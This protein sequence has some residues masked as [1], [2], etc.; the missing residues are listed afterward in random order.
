M[1]E[2]LSV[3]HA[4]SGGGRVHFGAD[5]SM[6]A[7]GSRP[8]D[9]SWG[10]TTIQRTN[11]PH[12]GYQSNYHTPQPLPVR[13]PMPMGMLTPTGAGHPPAFFSQQMPCGPQIPFQPIAYP[14][15]GDALPPPYSTEDASGKKLKKHKSFWR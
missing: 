11:V 12:F 4:T 5:G 6:S 2:H 9:V 3:F 1:N 10:F 7:G 13:P 8:G 14:V 15:L